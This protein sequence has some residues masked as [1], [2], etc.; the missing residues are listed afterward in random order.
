M[1]LIYEPG[2]GGGLAPRT[3]YVILSTRFPR[4]NKGVFL[5][6]LLFFFA[7]RGCLINVGG[8]REE[9]GFIRNI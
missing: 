3:R 1:E 7:A 5:L 6:P 8:M 4:R 9:F 2:G